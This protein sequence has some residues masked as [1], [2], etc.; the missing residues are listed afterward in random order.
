[1]REDTVEKELDKLQQGGVGTNIPRIADAIATN[2]DSGAFGFML[3]RTD[4][5][6][7]HGVAYFLPFVRWNVLL[8]D[9]EEGV[10]S[11]DPL[12][13]GSITR[14]NAMAQRRPTSLAYKVSHVV[15]NGNCNRVGN[16]EVIHQWKG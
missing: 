12:G 4:F 6:Y 8:I 3:F 1:L 16:V 2:G 11:R 14:A 10:R 15:Y 7:H 9:E 13:A 5:T